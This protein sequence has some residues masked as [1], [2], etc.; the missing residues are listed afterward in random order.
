MMTEPFSALETKSFIRKNKAEKYLKISLIEKF[1]KFKGYPSIERYITIRLLE[2]APKEKILS[3]LMEEGF[4]RRRAKRRI[5]ATIGYWR[6]T[7]PKHLG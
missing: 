5:D 4:D 1:M 7:H 6:K 3:E 2:G